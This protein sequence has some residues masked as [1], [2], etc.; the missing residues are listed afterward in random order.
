MATTQPRRWIRSCLLLLAGVLA[1]PGLTGCGGS[2][3]SGP[4]APAAI[5]VSV[6]PASVTLETGQSQS[7]AATVTG[8]TNADVTWQVLGGAT[9]GSIDAAGT[10]TAPT[11]VPNPATVTVRATSVADP[12]KS[13][14]ASVTVTVGA[15]PLPE[16]Q[17][18]LL[19]QVFRAGWTIQ[20]SINEANELL[21]QAVF[22]A[23]SLT[24]TLTQVGVTDEFN[25]SNSPGDRLRVVFSSGETLEFVVTDF[26]GDTDGTWEDFLYVHALAYTF[27]AP[28]LDVQ[29][30]SSRIRQDEY[31]RNVNQTIQGTATL[32]DLTWDIT[33]QVQG[34]ETFFFSNGS[35][36]DD[37]YSIEGVLTSGARR[38]EVYQAASYDF[39]YF[40]QSNYSYSERKDVIGSGGTD[41][42]NTIIF[43]DVTYRWVD[44]SDTDRIYQAEGSITRDAAAL[45]ELVTDSTSGQVGI[46]L[47]TGETVP[48]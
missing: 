44:T 11:S 23:E 24:G 42:T 35:D 25:Y 41:G 29:I 19:D 6:S 1:L 36:T 47:T 3:D 21:A 2:D 39:E 16:S 17:L 9:N 15:A 7:F 27:S 20:D 45:G 28:S 31:T 14:S 40:D 22:Y 12:S 10:Y 33:A 26:Q 4:T 46:Y 34:T 5:S 32:D 38:I 30:T 43:Q 18:A 8:T 48:F 13:S 37:D